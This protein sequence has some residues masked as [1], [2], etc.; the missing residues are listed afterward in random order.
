MASSVALSGAAP[1]LSAAASSMQ[2]PKKSPIFCSFAVRPA[3]GFAACSSTP[4]RNCRFSCASLLYTCQLAWSGG[5]GFSLSQLPHEK[6]QKSVHGS[7]LRSMKAGSR[8]GVYGSEASGRS[9]AWMAAATSVMASNSLMPRRLSHRGLSYRRAGVYAESYVASEP[10]KFQGHLNRVERDLAYECAKENLNAVHKGRKG[11]LRRYRSLLRGPWHRQARRPDSRISLERCVLGEADRGAS[12]RGLSCHHVRSQG[13][14]QV[15]PALHGLQL[16][17]V[18]RGP[19]QNRDQA[20]TARLRAGRFLHGR[21]RSGPVYREVR[22]QGCEQGRI[23][24]V[25]AALPAEDAR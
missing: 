5:I 23:H 12:R 25:G 8:L 2:A 3:A 19:A 4:Q 22:I 6:R 7:T 11:K 1:A 14:R 18:R 15:Q 24:F 13:L 16:R 20:R 17:H 10:Q 21:R 9:C